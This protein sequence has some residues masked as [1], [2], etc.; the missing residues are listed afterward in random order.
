MYSFELSLL[1]QIEARIVSLLFV[2]ELTE[3]VDGLAA[4]PLSVADVLGGTHNGNVQLSVTCTNVVP[5]DEVNVSEFT[6]VQNA[7]LNGHGL[8]A[9][10]EYGAEVTVGVHGG[11]VAGLVYVAAELSVD[12]TGMTVVTFVSVI[13]DQLTHNVEQVVLQILQIERVNVVG[14]LLNHYGASGVVRSDTNSAVL[15]T[16]CLYDLNDLFGYVVEGGDPASGLKLEFFLKYFEFHG[17]IPHINNRNWTYSAVHNIARNRPKVNT[18][19]Y[20]KG[21]IVLFM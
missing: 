8:A 9:A 18:I 1:L 5:V 3:S 20:I 19:S 15:D 10:E 16:G 14:A 6:A 7:V 12:R 2:S 4:V 11:V 21:K 13:G 17:D